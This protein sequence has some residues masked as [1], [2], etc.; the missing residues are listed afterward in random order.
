MEACGECIPRI[1]RA[2][3]IV[4]CCYGLLD[5]IISNHVST[6]TALFDHISTETIRV[7]VNMFT[8][9]YLE[10]DQDDTDDRL[11][12]CPQTRCLWCDG[13]FDQPHSDANDF[14][15]FCSRYCELEQSTQNTEME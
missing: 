1:S 12:A 3:R 13:L 14:E 15:R 4:L 7:E 8:D 5:S 10:S 2:S 6:E 9:D 11:E